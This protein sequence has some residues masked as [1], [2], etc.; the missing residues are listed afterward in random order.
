MRGPFLALALALSGCGV[1]A[2]SASP[3]AD[4][5][6]QAQTAR[7]SDARLAELYDGACRSCHGAAGGGAP[8]TLDRAAWAPRWRKGEQV[9]LEHTISGFNGMPAGGQCFG[10]TEA[11]YRALIAFMAGREE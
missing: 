7:P 2:P 4:V 6:Q 9:L 8:L 5:T 1:S 10:C 3:S 11:D